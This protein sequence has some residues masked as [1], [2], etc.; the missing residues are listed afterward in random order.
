MVGPRLVVALLTQVGHEPLELPIDIA[1]PVELPRRQ[2]EAARNL[3]QR[4]RRVA[5]GHDRRQRHARAGVDVDDHLVARAR[6]DDVRPRVDLGLQ[7]PLVVVDTLQER[8]QIV[9]AGQ[10]E[11]RA[12][13]LF[14]PIA[15]QAFGDGTW[16]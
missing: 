14:D 15:Q 13:P 4:H 5:L 7:V 2:V 9:E 16:P 6:L 8:P 12:K 1:L 3:G 11:G 10:R